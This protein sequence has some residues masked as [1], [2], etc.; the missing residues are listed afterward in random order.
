[1]ALKRYLK[2]TFGL[3]WGKD[4]LMGSSWPAVYESFQSF[5]GHSV[6]AHDAAAAA[7]GQ[8]L[9]LLKDHHPALQ[10]TPL[11]CPR[12]DSHLAGPC[13]GCLQLKPPQGSATGAAANHIRK[14]TS[15]LCQIHF[16]LKSMGHFLSWTPSFH[17][18]LFF[19][20]FWADVINHTGLS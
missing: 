8:G 1:M 9:W 19:K 13:P 5:P 3:Q 12:D 10:P 11:S 6:F 14:I 7:A 20:L 17:M 2:A 18:M 16:S 4:D 15:D